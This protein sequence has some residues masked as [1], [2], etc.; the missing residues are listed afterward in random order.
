VA[1]QAPAIDESLHGV[2]LAFELIW[3]GSAP[4]THGERYAE[5]DKHVDVGLDQTAFDL[6]AG[7]G[8]LERAIRGRSRAGDGSDRLRRRRAHRAFPIPSTC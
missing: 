4:S 2:D 5:G 3:C 7:C 1:G 8:P 6:A